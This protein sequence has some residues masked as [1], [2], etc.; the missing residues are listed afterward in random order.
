VDVALQRQQPQLASSSS[1]VLPANHHSTATVGVLPANHYSAPSPGV[2]PANHSQG[3]LPS[4]YYSA[5]IPGS[6]LAS[7]TVH[8]AGVLPA[9]HYSIAQTTGVL[10]A[11][12]NTGVLPA[13]HYTAS[14]KGILPANH[15]ASTT[16][17][18]PSTQASQYTPSNQQVSLQASHP[19]QQSSG[20]LPVDHYSHQTTHASTYA[21]FGGQPLTFGQTSQV[22]QSASLLPSIQSPPNQ[23]LAHSPTFQQQAG[24]QS[25]VQWSNS[26]PA[27]SQAPRTQ[28]KTICFFAVVFS[29][30]AL[31]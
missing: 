7:S 27:F 22:A 5:P 15:D 18:Q 23:L 12:Q 10:P 13:S 9:N 31:I 4:N 14:S 28:V 6:L 20:V 2:L 25:A 11:N 8:N 30:F 16:Q 1:G 3:V 19:H 29:K 21:Q 24:Q 17:S 26:A